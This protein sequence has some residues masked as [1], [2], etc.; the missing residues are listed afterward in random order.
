MFNNAWSTLNINYVQQC[1]VYSQLL[2]NVARQILLLRQLSTRY[3]R[4]H[5]CLDRHLDLR[6]SKPTF[7]V[8]KCFVNIVTYIQ[9]SHL[10]NKKCEGRKR[11]F[12]SGNRDSLLAL[13]H[14][15]SGLEYQSSISD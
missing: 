15:K 3:L 12:L 10:A 7:A 14:E 2:S 6:R 8:E 9:K 11:C 4:H 1:L 13:G 5:V